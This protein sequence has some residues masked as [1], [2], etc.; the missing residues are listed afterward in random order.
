VARSHLQGFD[1]KHEEAKPDSDFKFHAGDY[2]P[3]FRSG[4]QAGLKSTD[5]V[6][7]ERMAQ[8]PFVRYENFDVEKFSDYGKW[9]YDKK[10]ETREPVASDGN[11]AKG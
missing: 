6:V 10:E 8:R 1:A 2:R 9:K 5:Q 4:K 7:H 11:R 3:A